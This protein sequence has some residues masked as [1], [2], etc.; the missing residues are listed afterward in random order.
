MAAIHNQI[1]IANK[2]RSTA[3]P[4]PQT[5]GDVL[6]DLVLTPDFKTSVFSGMVTV[7][8]EAS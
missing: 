7:L 8:R 5:D 6:P 4:R 2:G 3:T 1:A